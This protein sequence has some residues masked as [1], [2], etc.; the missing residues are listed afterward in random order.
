MFVIAS[1]VVSI[2]I[3]N[4][5][6]IDVKCFDIIL[7]FLDIPVPYVNYLQSNCSTYIKSRIP[8]KELIEKGINFHDRNLYL[9]EYSTQ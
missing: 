1:I 4:A 6:I 8:V 5:M 9:E 3:Y 2:W 7:W